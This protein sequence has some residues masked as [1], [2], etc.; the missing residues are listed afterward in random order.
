VISPMQ[1][2]LCDSEMSVVK[3]EPYYS[4]H[5]HV[6]DYRNC[7]CSMF[8]AGRLCIGGRHAMRVLQSSH[9]VLSAF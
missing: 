1:C 7:F 6:F 9:A 2:F 4:I 3:V 8:A 5:M